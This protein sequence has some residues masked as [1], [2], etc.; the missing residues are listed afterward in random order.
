GGYG[1]AWVYGVTKSTAFPTAAPLQATYGGN[2]DAFVSEFDTTLSGAASLRMSTYL[3]GSDVEEELGGIALD[4]S[5]SAHLVGVTRSTN[6]PT[7]AGALDTTIGG[8]V[9]TFVAQIG[10]QST[11]TVNSANDADDGACDATHCSLREAIRAANAHPGQDLIRFDIPGAGVHVIN[12]GLGG[13]PAVTD[14]VTISASSQPGY[15][16]SPLIF[17]SGNDT[18]GGASGFQLSA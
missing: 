2:Q 16:D 1:L 14:Q 8:T 7:T 11:F 3:G 17:L 13:L 5:G 15:K 18:G 9:D 10:T 6:F 12:V 4:A